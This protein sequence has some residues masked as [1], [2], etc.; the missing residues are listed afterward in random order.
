MIQFTIGRIKLTNLIIGE[1]AKHT[2]IKV[3]YVDY[4]NHEII[5]GEGDFSIIEIDF[6]DDLSYFSN[7]NNYHKFRWKLSINEFI[8]LCFTSIGLQSEDMHTYTISKTKIQF[9]CEER[10][11]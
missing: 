9:I 4:I 3:T 2:N 10:N 5:F 8:Q 6:I 7:N 1:L 11:N